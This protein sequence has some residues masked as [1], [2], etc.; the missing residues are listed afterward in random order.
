MKTKHEVKISK[1]I[2]VSKETNVML[3]ATD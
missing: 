1:Y 2:N 3:A